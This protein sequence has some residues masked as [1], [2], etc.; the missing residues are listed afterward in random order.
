MKP[1]EEISNLS[2]EAIALLGDMFNEQYRIGFNYG[3][4]VV[5]IIFTKSKEA[6][7]KDTLD[8]VTQPYS[9]EYLRTLIKNRYE[10]R[11]N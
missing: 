7:L 4:S 8:K 9:A 6:I 5:G 1:N 3:V 11:S 2:D 10:P